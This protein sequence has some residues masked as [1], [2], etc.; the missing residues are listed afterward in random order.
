MCGV[1]FFNNHC[2]YNIGTITTEDPMRDILRLVDRNS[3][4]AFC[5]EY[6]DGVGPVCD[7][8]LLKEVIIHRGRDIIDFSPGEEVD[9]LGKITSFNSCGLQIGQMLVERIPK[10][11]EVLGF[12]GPRGRFSAQ[13]FLQGREAS[14]LYVYQAAKTRGVFE[15]HLF[16][17]RKGVF[18]SLPGFKDWIGIPELRF[19]IR[20]FLDEEIEEGKSA[21]EEERRRVKVAGNIEGF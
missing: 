7:P 1:D 9:L 8:R 19:K 11:R 15:A 17:C 2:D 16:V 4:N 12:A 5:V 18:S 13:T 21:D 14:C 6:R 20:E 3:I 10:A